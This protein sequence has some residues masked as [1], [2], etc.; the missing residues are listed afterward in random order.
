M[1]GCWWL[2]RSQQGSRWGWQGELQV[3]LGRHWPGWQ[4]PGWGAG[5]VGVA[6]GGGEGPGGGGG[7]G[8]EGAS[9]GLAGAGA[10]AEEHRPQVAA[11]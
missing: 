10:G 4:A 3:R 1:W 8:D 6:R 5:G 7:D 11:Q 9:T 2:L